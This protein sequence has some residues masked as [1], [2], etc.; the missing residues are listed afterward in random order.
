MSRFVGSSKNKGSS[1]VPSVSSNTSG[2]LLTNDGSQGVWTGGFI[3]SSKYLGGVNANTTN[4]NKTATATSFSGGTV[5]FGNTAALP[6]NIVVSS[7]GVFTGNV[8]GVATSPIIIPVTLTES[9][10]GSV[11]TINY[12]LGVSLTNSLPSFNT[13]STFTITTVLAGNDANY[14]ISATGTGLSYALTNSGNLPAGSTVNASTGVLNIPG[15]SIYTSGTFSYN[16]TVSVTSSSEP[17]IPISLTVT[18]ASLTVTS[19]VGQIQYDGAYGYNG[20]TCTTTFTVPGGV[21]SISAM[22]I[23]GGGGGT[24]SW[25]TCGGHGSGMAWIN[26]VPV[27][28]GATY[29]IASGNGGCWS[30]SVGGCSCMAGLFVA[31]GGCCGC[32][33]GCYYVN[34]G[35]AATYGN[36]CNCCAGGGYGMVAYPSTAG[37]GGGGPSYVTGSAFGA[38]DYGTCGATNTPGY[39]GVGGSGGSGAALHS[40][41]YGT[42]G[43]G[44]TGAC[45]MCCYGAGGCCG[46]AGY[47]YQTGSGGQ[48]GSGGTC[49]KPGEPWSNGSGNGYGCGGSYGGGGGGGGTSHGGGWGGQGTVRIV[50]PGTTRQWP[51]CGVH[52]C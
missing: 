5:T 44:G 12:T 46:N 1:I 37:G 16:F 32:Y 51:C 27:T 24:Y 36:Y 43:G 33:G 13:G 42:G 49:G 26:N 20:G 2:A 14:T 52:N 38:S 34:C 11:V 4:I 39:H 30:G 21:S 45:G 29:T 6:Y 48:G 35:C 25:A 41:T 31:C 23:G 15:A 7:S 28:P 8:S 47:S 40:S 22:G 19:P 3:T 10:Y 9:A 18:S 17:L 50:W